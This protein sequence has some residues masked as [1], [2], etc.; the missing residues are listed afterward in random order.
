MIYITNMIVDEIKKKKKNAD[1]RWAKR[2]DLLLIGMSKTFCCVLLIALNKAHLDQAKHLLTLMK[3]NHLRFAPLD[4]QSAKLLPL[5]TCIFLT[6]IDA[7]WFH[8]D[9]VGERCG[10]K[11]VGGPSSTLIQYL[12]NIRKYDKNHILIYFISKFRIMDFTSYRFIWQFCAP[13]C[14]VVPL[15]KFCLMIMGG[16][17][18]TSICIAWTTNRLI[19]SKRFKNNWVSNDCWIV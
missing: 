6:V 10:V 8:I 19:H 18:Y 17:C 15:L 2:K 9:G 14:W 16:I 11:G 13:Y 5:P 12:S 4:D 3:K 1:P 7:I